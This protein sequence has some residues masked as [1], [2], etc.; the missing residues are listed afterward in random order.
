MNEMKP[1]LQEISFDGIH[2]WLRDMKVGAIRKTL[3]FQS[4]IPKEIMQSEKLRCLGKIIG[5]TV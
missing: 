5:E 4:P 3:K 1:V 2:F